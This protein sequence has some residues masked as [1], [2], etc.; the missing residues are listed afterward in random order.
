MTYFLPLKG[1]EIGLRLKPPP[2]HTHPPDLTESLK[3]QYF[4]TLDLLKAMVTVLR[5]S[6]TLPRRH[7]TS[8]DTSKT[9]QDAPKTPPS[10]D[11]GGFWNLK[12]SQVETKITS[13]SDVMLK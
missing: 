13:R 7:K 9:P 3:N 8:Q 10:H 2:S 5:C 11:F 12:W 6:K 1:P 4:Q